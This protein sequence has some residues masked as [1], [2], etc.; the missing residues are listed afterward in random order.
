M[1]V[2]IF[3]KSFGYVQKVPSSISLSFHVS[4]VAIVRVSLISQLVSHFLLV[5]VLISS[6]M[7]EFVIE[8][9]SPPDTLLI[10]SDHIVESQCTRQKSDTC[11]CT[12]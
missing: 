5:F 3:V 2:V 9:F 7:E 10:H 12:G 6:K 8:H 1:F 11:V 4:T